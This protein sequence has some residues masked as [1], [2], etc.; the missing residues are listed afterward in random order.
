MNMTGTDRIAAL[1][2]GLIAVG[3]TF[4]VGLE[5]LVTVWPSGWSWGRG[6][7]HYLPMILGVYATL[8]VFL[9]L[10]SRDPMR[11]RSLIWFTIW[12]SV[13]HA[14]VMGG[15]AAGDPAESGH[16]I[17]DVP[18]LLIVAMALGMLMRRAERATAVTDLGARRVA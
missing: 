15:M 7:S 10:A 13:V 5:T 2:Y 14:V 18:A 16:L 6:H 3:V 8:G 11:N 1:R 4:I 12:S 17:G 9:I